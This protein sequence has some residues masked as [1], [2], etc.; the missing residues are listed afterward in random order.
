MR[1]LSPASGSGTS[2]TWIARGPSRVEIW[3]ARTGPPAGG[4][5]WAPSLSDA[6]AVPL[7]GSGSRRGLLGLD[8]RVP[9][10]LGGLPA[11][12]GVPA[13]PVAGDRGPLR[14]QAVQPAQMAAQLADGVGLAVH[15]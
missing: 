13:P 6:R 3:A 4:G 11:V 1:T 5:R 2:T 7:P 10:P 14:C 9:L 8:L 15:E 12:L